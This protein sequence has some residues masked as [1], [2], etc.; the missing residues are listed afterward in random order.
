MNYCLTGQMLARSP[1]ADYVHRKSSAPPALGCHQIQGSDLELLPGTASISPAPA[2]H[3]SCGGS[4]GRAQQVTDTAS[5]CEALATQ[6]AVA[7]FPQTP[8]GAA[9]EMM[10]RRCCTSPWGQAAALPLRSGAALDVPRPWAD[11]T[12]RQIAHSGSRA[13]RRLGAE[14][15]YHA[16]HGLLVGAAGGALQQR[17]ETA[18]EP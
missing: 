7:T 14:A 3:W 10:R 11:G 13:D 12:P 9:V 6:L 1:R 8:P 17:P 2:H 15:I 18:V 4:L 5:P 16:A